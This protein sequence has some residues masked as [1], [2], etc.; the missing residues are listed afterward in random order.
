MAKSFFQSR[1][2]Q[3]GAYAA[4]ALLAVA[5]VFVFWSWRNT[6][7]QD[8]I[9][10]LPEPDRRALY[11]RTLETLTASCER[12]TRPSGLEAFCQQQAEFILQFPEC[13]T[14]CQSLAR[15]QRGTPSR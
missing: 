6:L 1:S 12:G 4:L 2:L 8:A 14:S 7:E 5:A 11:Q 9:R 15:Q 10:R 13:D 3:R